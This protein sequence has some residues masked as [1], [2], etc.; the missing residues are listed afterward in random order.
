MDIDEV[1]FRAHQAVCGINK[2]KTEHSKGLSFNNNNNSLVG[3]LVYWYLVIMSN[4]SHIPNWKGYLRHT[5][6]DN[7][8]LL[9]TVC[10]TCNK[11]YDGYANI[12]D[13]CVENVC[14]YCN[15]YAWNRPVIGYHYHRV[16]HGGE[17]CPIGNVA[18]S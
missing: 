6:N 9:S 18:D 17:P 11:T 5:W 3:A 10:V 4:A 1:S 16:P 14:R 8:K 13:S 15:Y 12:C 7:I 2:K